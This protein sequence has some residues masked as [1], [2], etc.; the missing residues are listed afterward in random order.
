MKHQVSTL[1][2]V[3][4]LITCLRCYADP[5][6]DTALQLIPQDPNRPVVSANNTQPIVT[7]QP[8]LP[9]TPPQ[10]EVKQ[11]FTSQDAEGEAE[12]TFLD[13]EGHWRVLHKPQPNTAKP[14]Q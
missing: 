7:L 1:V 11:E 14:T 12:T 4:A 13:A 5:M 10:P 6:L 2:L 8:Q 9:S 3:L